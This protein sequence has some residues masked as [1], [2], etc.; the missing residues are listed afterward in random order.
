MKL[1]NLQRAH[2]AT[3]EINST[4]SV[5]VKSISDASEHMITNTEDIKI[6]A[7]ESESS[8]DKM[9]NVINKMNESVKLT[10]KTVDDFIETDMKVKEMTVRIQ[11][12]NSLVQQ[13]GS[14]V[15]EISS[16]SDHLHTI[17]EKLNS[18]IDK[19]KV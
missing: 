17:T 7:S 9:D 6:L 4:I 2:K 5:I 8:K 13:T 19:F 1:E 3:G 16:A 15:E 10:E 18:K 12:I 14:S 11:E